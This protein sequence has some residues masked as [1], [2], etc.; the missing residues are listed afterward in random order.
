M[1]IKLA[2]ALG[3]LFA[4]APLAAPKG[5]TQSLTFAAFCDALDNC[6]VTGSG[7]TPS[8]SYV[9]TVVDSCNKQVISTSV[10]TNGSG[11]LNVT[12]NG[13]AESS[14]CNATGWTFT[15]STGGRRSSVVASSFA[16][17]LE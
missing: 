4:L 11:V 1:K 5:R 13:V 16:A 2:F 14:G 12:L 10:N 17:D 7:L 3:V 15:L 8:T 9:L 6:T